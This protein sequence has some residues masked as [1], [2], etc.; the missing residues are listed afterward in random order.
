ML[1]VPIIRLTTYDT[2]DTKGIKM[3]MEGKI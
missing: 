3:S 1:T 2:Y